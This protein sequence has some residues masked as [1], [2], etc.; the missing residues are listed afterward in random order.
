MLKGLLALLLVSSSGLS[1]IR[2][3]DP[4]AGQ[5]TVATNL[6]MY[7]RLIDS[8][9]V[10]LT[11]NALLHDTA[12]PVI[13]SLKGKND[14]WFIGQSIGQTFRRLGY[15]AYSDSSAVTEKAIRLEVMPLFSVVYGDPERDGFLGPQKVRRTVKVAFTYQLID[16]RSS[17]ILASGNVSKEAADIVYKDSIDS[18][19][20]D[21]I[22]STK[23]VVPDDSNFDRIIAPLFIIGAAGTAVY[24]FFHV[25]S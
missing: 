19:Q 17:E 23:A 7:Q 12:T 5:D 2:N 14:F 25:R 11:G 4:P 10:N 24:L 20:N 1:S 15:R 6:S 9:I 18:L 21:S 22:P 16:A 8:A 13:I 3:D